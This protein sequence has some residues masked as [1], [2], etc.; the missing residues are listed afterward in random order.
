MRY[1]IFIL[2]VIMGTSCQTST[3]DRDA[4]LNIFDEQQK[5]WNEGDLEGFM[6]GYWKS[7][8]LKF[9]GKS[10]I[11]H[12]W[13]ATLDNYKKSYP[14]K[15][16]MGQLKFDILSLEV[17]GDVAFVLGKW[18]LIRDDDEPNGHFT[19]FWKKIDGNWR[20]I[21]DHSS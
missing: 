3:K 15:A 14:D 8:S 19:L 16:A 17:E 12:G 10:G 9:V 2:I 20:I 21:I 13:Q 6:E 18:K 7:D 5:A 4:I 11:N 1:F